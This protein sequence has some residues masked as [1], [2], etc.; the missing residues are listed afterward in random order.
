MAGDPFG[1][2]GSTSSGSKDPFGRSGAAPAKKT[3]G[4]LGVVERTGSD[5]YHA[6]VNTP[7]GV[8]YL[9]KG[10]A[11][12][13]VGTVKAVA[14]STAQDFE[15]PLRHP[16]NTLLDVL[17]VLSAGAGTAARI[18]AVSKALEEAA[19]AGDVAKAA[20]TKPNPGPR[21]FQVGDM[22]VKGD[23]SRSALTRGV[24]K[25][26]DKAL[27]NGAEKNPTGAAARLYERR[28]SKALSLNTRYA[29][30]A[31]KGP[32]AALAALGRHLKPE[33][34]AALKVVANEAPLDARIA[35][36]KQ[37]I[38]SASSVT[39]AKRHTE[40][41]TN[42][43][44]ASKLLTTDDKGLPKLKSS[45]PKLQHV[46]DRLSAVAA[47]REDL[48]K[49]IDALTPE[50]IAEHKSQVLRNAQG[51]PLVADAGPKPEIPGQLALQTEPDKA[52]LP[53]AS[54]NAVYV[55]EKVTRT[56]SK[57]LGQMPGMGAQGTIGHTKTPR[58]LTAGYSG[59]AAQHAI[60]RQDTTRL[61]A[62]ANLEAQKYGAVLHLKDTLKG[63]GHKVP[64]RPSDVFMRLDK[65]KAHEATPLPVRRFI[66]N[67][68]EAFVSAED[69]HG[70]FAQF[71]GEHFT[72][73]KDMTPK[74]RE[75]FQKLADQGKG[76]WVSKTL[77]G[78][79]AK[80]HTPLRAV[81]GTKPVRA[82]DAINNASRFAILYLKP[83]YAAPNLLGNAALNLIQQGPVGLVRTLHD[84][85]KLSFSHPEL[86]ARIDT[87]M[88]EGVAQSVAGKGESESRLAG[89]VQGA[90]NVWS[91]GVDTPFRRSAFMFEARKAGYRTPAQLEKLLTD[92]AHHDQLLSVTRRANREIID[93]GKMGPREREIV[94]RVVF[95][96]PWVKGSTMYAGHLLA[97][98]PVQAAALG[99]IGKEGHQK[100]QAAL[101]N[102]PSYLEGSFPV[103]GKLV[104]PT[105]AA[106]LQ[107]PAQ[108]GLALSGLLSGN[109]AEVATLSN[110]LTPAATL[111]GAETFRRNP[112][113]GAAYP[114]GENAGSIAKQVLGNSLPQA[115]LYQRIHDAL[116]H[117]GQ[118]KLYPP[119]VGDAL[120]QFLIG[121]LSPRKFNKAQLEK[122]YQREQTQIR[123][124]R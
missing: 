64:Q 124:G 74:D 121:G 26:T 115:V 70:H 60:E 91:K 117:Q 93:Y 42:L 52:P 2:G 119:N 69:R 16:G 23:Y 49:K 96:Y 6:A 61:V 24:Q 38:A 53:T 21:T 45:V 83:A 22:K 67:P 32:A 75:A 114:G 118:G 51:L 62:E 101:G 66:D 13:P 104:N 35:T 82:I 14:K 31:A 109:G 37:R 46:M 41:L 9:G 95:F 112:S 47:D 5:L 40:R 106:I 48:L 68:G 1:R 78:D 33:E 123:T 12:D 113:T 92:E 17:G 55:P 4:I 80:P 90:A 111:A 108:V 10:L 76:V 25:A 57:S 59:K 19:T 102:V 77:L 87:L 56:G 15:H 73:Q 71:L 107:T 84:T 103:G 98:H 50:G 7:A 97:E 100:A 81:A 110:F 65:L 63:A 94:R 86:T 88:G 54:Q 85:S 18:G 105:S 72:A 89:A 99:E 30:E 36:V 79:F 29:T 39:E 116:T 11:T 27:A 58:S 20:L 34:Q 43:E 122:L 120:R 8:Y 44:R 28:T 3:G